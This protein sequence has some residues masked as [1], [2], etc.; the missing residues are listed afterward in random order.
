MFK[1]ASFDNMTSRL[2]GNA[3]RNLQPAFAAARLRAPGTLLAA[4]AILA[5]YSIAQT[6]DS[7]FTTLYSFAGGSDGA[8]PFARV[9]IGPNGV[10]YGTTRYGGTSNGGTVF[11]LTPPSSESGAWTETILYRFPNYSSPSAGL[12]IGKNGELYGTTYFGGASGV[13]SVFELIPPSSSSGTWAET[14]LYSFSA[15]N[16]DPQNPAAGV[17]IGENGVLY[18]AT[19]YGGFSSNCTFYGC[20][21]VFALTPPASGSGAWT[22]NT[23]YTFMGGNDGAVIVEDLI[24][25][26]NGALYG[27]TY[28]GGSSLNCSTGFVLG[29]GTIF[30]IT[31][32]SAPGLAWTET[33]LY[34]FA[35]GQGGGFPSAVV[36][37]DN[38]LYGTTQFGGSMTACGGF[39]CGA[40]FELTQ[41]SSTEG[42]WTETVPY[43]FNGVPNG[44]YPA[45][46][47]LGSINAFSGT[48]LVIGNNGEL[49]GATVDGGNSTNC[50]ENPGCGAIF[51]LTPPN[52]SNGAW[53]ET[54]LHSF[55]GADGFRPYTGVV[56]GKNGALYGTTTYG[57]TSTACTG[58]CGTVYELKP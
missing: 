2:C 14:T 21:V 57:G 39:G 34:T 46:G 15:P 18:G 58:G 53:T 44:L 30:E 41:P 40:V 50:P 55:T 13:G 43:G 32:P 20:G 17:V 42:A 56:I 6:A 16:G 29:C 23:L 10:L 36:G 5:P 3:C 48:G 25:G 12:A 47:Y 9:T 7:A 11:Q 28:S 1:R 22:E 49:Y 26:K 51:E 45:P 31:P 4:L 35:G 54:V 38:A 24:I 52:S 37:N 19:Q 33:V 27:S 8:S